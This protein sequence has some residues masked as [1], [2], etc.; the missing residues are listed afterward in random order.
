VAQYPE[1][2]EALRQT[3]KLIPQHEVCL[4]C[5]CHALPACPHF[6]GLAL[7]PNAANMRMQRRVGRRSM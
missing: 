4:A 2:I 6:L 7:E 3:R 1:A 5:R